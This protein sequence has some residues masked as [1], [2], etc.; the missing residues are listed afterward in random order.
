M[1]SQAARIVPTCS[2]PRPRDRNV[3]VNGIFTDHFPTKWPLTYC[4]I[5][6]KCGVAFQRCRL[7]G[8][9]INIKKRCDAAAVSDL[10]V[11]LL[12]VRYLCSWALLNQILIFLLCLILSLIPP[13]RLM[14]NC[15]ETQRSHLIS[16][17]GAPPEPTL[18]LFGGEVCTARLTLLALT[19]S[20]RLL[21][22]LWHFGKSLFAPPDTPGLRL[23]VWLRFYLPFSFTWRI[24]IF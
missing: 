4:E 6:L 3:P 11:L 2:H 15:S 12:Q 19:F 21:C 5:V 1:V 20:K 9:Y 22:F 10:A 16:E 8:F 17:A 18:R 14:S 7:S 24:I 23:P 13:L